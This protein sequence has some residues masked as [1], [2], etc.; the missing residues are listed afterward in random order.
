MNNWG[1]DQTFSYQ[2]GGEYLTTMD[3]SA[4]TFEFKVADANWSEANFGGEEGQMMLSQAKILTSNESD[5]SIDINTAGEYDFLLDMLSSAQPQ[6][7][8]SNHQ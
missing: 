2:G 3:L 1:I 6:L 7:T 4:Q 5:L 8:I